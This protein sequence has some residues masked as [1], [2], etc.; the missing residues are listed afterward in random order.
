MVNAGISL[1][2]KTV[3]EKAAESAMREICSI[4]EALSFVNMDYIVWLDLTLR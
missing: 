2:R 3:S 4:N 1:I